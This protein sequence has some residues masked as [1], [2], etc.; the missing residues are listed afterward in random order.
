MTSQKEMTGMGRYKVKLN[1]SRQGLTQLMTTAQVQFSTQ[2]MSG[3]TPLNF[4]QFAMRW[5]SAVNLEFRKVRD[6]R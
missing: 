1:D 3:F 5:R 4:K 2:I 6:D